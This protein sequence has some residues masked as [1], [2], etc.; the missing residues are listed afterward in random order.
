MKRLAFQ[1]RGGNS[2]GHVKV[3]ERNNSG[4]GLAC[5]AYLAAVAPSCRSS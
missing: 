5:R 4:V 2:H 1:M 3:G